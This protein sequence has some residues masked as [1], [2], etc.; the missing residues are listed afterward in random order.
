MEYRTKINYI[1]GSVTA[2]SGVATVASMRSED[3]ISLAPLFGLVTFVGLAAFGI[4]K[5]AQARE[6]SDLE[7]RID[8]K[9]SER[10]G[11][12]R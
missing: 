10:N 9:R 11:K 3:Y 6:K 5:I 8:N 2:M 12:V 1:A 4:N 7:N